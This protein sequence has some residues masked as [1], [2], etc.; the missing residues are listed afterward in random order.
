MKILED[1]KQLS[2]L[3]L[4]MQLQVKD[5]KLLSQTSR[6]TAMVQQQATYFFNY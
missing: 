6:S 4:E 5:W 1:K 2:P 3:L